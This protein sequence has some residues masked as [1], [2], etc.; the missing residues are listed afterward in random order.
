[1]NPQLL[2]KSFMNE[3]PKTNS[4]LKPEPAPTENQETQSNCQ[5]YL[6]DPITRLHLCNSCDYHKYR[7]ESK[8]WLK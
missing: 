8:P 4:T 3:L 6:V 5:S 2:I 1:M 7:N